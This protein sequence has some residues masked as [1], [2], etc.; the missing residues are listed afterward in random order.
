MG[1]T[2]EPDGIAVN[3]Y[4]TPAETI[5][6]LREKTRALRDAVSGLS[7][8]THHAHHVRLGNMKPFRECDAGVCVEARRILAIYE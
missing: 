5:Q 4:T 8:A 3:R 6:A 7:L 2:N 1:N